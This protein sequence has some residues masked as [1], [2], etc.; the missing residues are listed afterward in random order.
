MHGQFIKDMT[1]GT[2]KEKL[3]LWMRKYDLK[4]PPQALICPAQEQAIR[5][6]NYV[7]YH[8]CKC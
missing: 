7:K 5:R 4:I 3:W 8:I 1:Q 6:T 2:D